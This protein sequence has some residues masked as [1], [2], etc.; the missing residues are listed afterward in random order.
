MPKLAPKGASTDRSGAAGKS[1]VLPDA[2]ELWLL[3]MGSQA[4][5]AR[6]APASLAECPLQVSQVAGALVNRLMTLP[7]SHGGSTYRTSDRQC[8]AAIRRGAQASAFASR[9]T[10]PA[11]FS[12]A[13][14][15]R[16]RY[17]TSGCFADDS[18]TPYACR[19]ASWTAARSQTRAD[20]HAKRV[21]C[22]CFG[23]GLR[24]SP[25]DKPDGT[26]AANG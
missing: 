21:E 22:G 4:F 2:I 11:T 8:E 16:P 1:D 5:L 19:R 3:T 13:A 6:L 15:T 17:E 20:G 7:S 12:V 24:Q 14:R 9:A 10:C 18:R 26:P 25:C 23:L